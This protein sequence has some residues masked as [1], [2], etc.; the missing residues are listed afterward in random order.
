MWVGEWWWFT[1]RGRRST[2]LFISSTAWRRA[3]EGR[4]YCY[5]SRENHH[6]TYFLYSHL[7]VLNSVFG[8]DWEVCAYCLKCSYRVGIIPSCERQSFTMGCEAAGELILWWSNW[9][10]KIPW[11]LLPS[12]MK[13]HVW[14]IF[15]NLSTEKQN[16]VVCLQW[17]TNPALLCY[18][19]FKYILPC[20]SGGSWPLYSF[21][22]DIW[23]LS[24]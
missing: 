1:H 15:L 17:E 19:F 2:W 21:S 10:N 3:P 12:A 16:A 14:E 23:E 6:H 9:N 20:A 22:S 5:P 8:E 13:C 18:C 4:R 11:Y 24:L 7:C